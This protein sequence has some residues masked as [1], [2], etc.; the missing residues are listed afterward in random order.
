MLKREGFRGPRQGELGGL[1]AQLTGLRHKVGLQFLLHFRTC[2]RV[3]PSVRTIISVEPNALTMSHIADTTLT[4]E[5][6]I[7][8]PG[9]RH[10][11][12]YER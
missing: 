2:T 8:D 12:K 5:S 11:M 6:R 3:R 4:E 10:Y 9:A 7:K 1:N